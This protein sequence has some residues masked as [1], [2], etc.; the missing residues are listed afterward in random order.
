MSSKERRNSKRISYLCEVEWE[1]NGS[2]VNTRINDLSATGAFIDSMTCFNVGS[3]LRMKFQVGDIEIETAAEVRYAMQNVG[4]GVK[5]VDLKPEHVAL[6]KSLVDGK[7]QNVAAGSSG[8]LQP[9]L[10]GDFAIICLFDVIQMI[11]NSRLTGTLFV[12]LKD[13]TGAVHFN[14]GQIARAESG[15]EN[16][17][18]ALNNFVDAT[19]GTFE[20]RKSDSPFERT[21][22]AQSNAG[23]LLD[24]LRNKEEQLAFKN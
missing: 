16:D 13:K 14:D 20:F 23:V 3:V 24:L 2:R 18:A 9:V 5:F 17:V 19:E 15:A 8:S 10:S 4:M 21:I 6:L 1:G 22:Y 7:P 12:K 11:E